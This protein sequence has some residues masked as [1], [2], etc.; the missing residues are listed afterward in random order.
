MKDCMIRC[1]EE[2]KTAIRK[3]R[4]R[5]VKNKR[6][7]NRDTEAQLLAETSEGTI[8]AILTLEYLIDHPI[9]ISVSRNNS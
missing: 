2:T 9:N 7:Q 3:V 5:M 1:S 8:V 4:D 6:D